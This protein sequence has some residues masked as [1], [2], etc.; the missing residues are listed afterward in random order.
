[1]VVI[2]GMV[3]VVVGMRCMIWREDFVLESYYFYNV[4]DYRKEDM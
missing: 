3:R 1:M 4:F 2:V